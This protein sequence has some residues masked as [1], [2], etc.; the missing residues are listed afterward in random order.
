MAN[1]NSD[2]WSTESFS[3]KDSCTSFLMGLS[4]NTKFCI[5]LTVENT[6][7]LERLL[8]ILH[9]FAKGH[10]GYKSTLD[11]TFLSTAKSGKSRIKISFWIRQKECTLT[12]PKWDAPS[13]STPPSPTTNHP[14]Y[15]FE[16]DKFIIS[17]KKLSFALFFALV[18]DL[19]HFPLK[20]WN[21]FICS[22]VSG[23]FLHLFTQW[24]LF[25]HQ[26]DDF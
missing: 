17:W 13:P 16:H 12:L 5:C 1:P 3:K 18:W 14:I 25:W 2:F 6:S 15:S 23:A 22:L 4:S 11:F 7:F 21:F 10:Q 24:Q 8:C 9:A 26:N 20:I 19:A